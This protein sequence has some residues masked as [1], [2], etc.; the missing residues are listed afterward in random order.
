[1]HRP[2]YYYTIGLLYKYMPSIRDIL[3][4][5]FG[6]LYSD[7]LFRLLYSEMHVFNT[8]MGCVISWLLVVGHDGAVATN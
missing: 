3:D 8:R 6:R 4:I 5:L 2:S 7:I 1:M